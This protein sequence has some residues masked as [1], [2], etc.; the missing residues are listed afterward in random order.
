MQSELAVEVELYAPATAKGEGQR[1]RHESS[2][3][4]I[5]RMCE[6]EAR[7]E[8][9]AWHSDE[10]DERTSGRCVLAVRRELRDGRSRRRA[11]DGAGLWLKWAVVVQA[12]CAWHGVASPWCSKAKAMSMSMS[13]SGSPGRERQ[14]HQ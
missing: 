7:S 3:C 11:S 4:R 9:P 6:L 2:R 12:A 5:G 1:A 10:S 13:M 14:V 8:A